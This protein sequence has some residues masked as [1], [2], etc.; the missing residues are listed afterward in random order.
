MRRTYANRQFTR[1]VCVV[2]LALVAH[3]SVSAASF[4]DYRAR[5]NVALER[6]GDLGNALGGNGETV[7]DAR[8]ARALAGL[9]AT[10]PPRER[11]ESA[12]GSIEVDNRWLEKELATFDSTHDTTRRLEIAARVIVKLDALK[13]ELDA[14]AAA[15]TP[16]RD[17]EAEKGRLQTILRRPEYNQQ[18]ARGGALQSL[19]EAVKDFLRRLIPRSKPLSASR[20][21]SPLSVAARVFIYALA[22]AVI[23][24][25]LWRFGPG[26]WARFSARRRKSQEREARIVLGERLAADETAAHLLS[27]AERLARAGDLRGA[28]RKA[29]VAVLCE[30]G[31]RK[32]IRLARHKT[33]RD[34]LAGVRDRA[35]LYQL[36][37]PLTNS[38]ERHWYGFDPAT[39][40]D[41]DEYRAL[42]NEAIKC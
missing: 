23:I 33:N 37:R 7:D 27:E 8:A 18:A 1:A 29:Y 30:L 9:R 25:V 38:F 6:A 22:A 26:A 32:V 41:W 14:T 3:V 42:C 21:A 17:K 24:F 15:A 35:E 4:D 12:L 11:V 19:W 16:A 2:V 10:L 31:D 39:P 20:Y 28:I 13:R 5:V 40:A 36:L 34:Y